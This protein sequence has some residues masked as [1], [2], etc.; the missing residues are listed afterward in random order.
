MEENKG[1]AAFLK[2]NFDAISK[3]F[4]NHIAMCVFS[5]VVILAIQMLTEKITK[6][7][8]AKMGAPAYIASAFATRFCVGKRRVSPLEWTFQ[9]A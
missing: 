1:F 5:M 4:L 2:S 8:D 6:N 3:L 7:E 9:Y